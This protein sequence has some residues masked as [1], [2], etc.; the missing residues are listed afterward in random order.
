MPTVKFT[1]ALL[2][3]E[4]TPQLSVATGVP[5]LNEARETVHPEVILAVILAGTV[6]DGKIVSTTVIV[7]DAEETFPEAS[8]TYTVT[9]W[10]PPKGVSVQS[11]VKEV[12]VNAL[13]KA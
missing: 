11:K 6:I 10:F 3:I 7:A 8:C 4:N 5:R 2:V 12:V 9:V 13:S 1:G